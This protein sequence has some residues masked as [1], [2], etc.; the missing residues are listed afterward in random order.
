[1]GL[2]L[3]ASGCLLKDRTDTWYLE[4]NGVVTWSVLE[5]DVRSDANAAAD[6]Q[7][8]E[9]TYMTDV[10]NQVH[11]IASGFRALGASEIR[12]KILRGSIPYSVVTEARF[13]SIEAMGQ[14]LIVRTGLSGSSIL[15]RDAV[16]AVW[17]LTMRDP[18]APDT[19]DQNDQ[20][21]GALVEGLAG[22]KVTLTD[23]RFVAAG[24]QG[25]DISSDGRVATLLADK[26]DEKAFEDGS[27]IVKRL[28][29]VVR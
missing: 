28:K 4:P 11:P 7:K 15:E 6:R 25:F 19:P 3:T 22:L 1:M 8:E 17:T 24:S 16:G 20:D 12:T 23:G 5:K 10:R 13:A 18:H 29:W 9:S 26:D 2:A 14:A 27:L 21:T